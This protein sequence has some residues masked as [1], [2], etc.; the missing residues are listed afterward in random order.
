MRFFARRRKATGDALQVSEKDGVRSLHF[1]S[2]VVQ[3]AM[4][5]SRPWD[6]ELDYTRRMMAFLLFHPR[7]RH[8]I[9]LGLGGGSLA[10]FIHHHLPHTRV[11]AVELDTRVIEVARS[12]FGLPADDARLR[13]IAGDG[14]SL[15]ATGLPPADVIMVDGYNA[16]GI[17]ETLASEAFYSQCRARLHPERGVLLANFWR[18]AR[19]TAHYL[20][21]LERLFDGHLLHLPSVTHGNLI[22]MAFRRSPGAPRFDE[23]AVRAAEL[24]DQLPL[25]FTEFL[26][27]LRDN[28]PHT[29]RRLLA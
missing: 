5:L 8:A 10:K 1:G 25:P 13:V 29:E 11:T 16:A 9:I 7:P 15:M 12:Q 21:R 14:A 6:L 23:L 18:S 3:S 26:H 4:R 2:V 22:V 17:D 19:S 27:G 20:A 28:N 24:E